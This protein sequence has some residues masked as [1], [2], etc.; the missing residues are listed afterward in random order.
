MS[1]PTGLTGFTGLTGPTGFTGYTGNT[2]PVGTATVV[3][4]YVGLTGT[5][6]AEISPNT[7]IAMTKDTGLSVSTHPYLFV[8]GVTDVQTPGY[9]TLVGV[10]PYTSGGTWNIG[11]NL[12]TTQTTQDGFVSGGTVK[13]YTLS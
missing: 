7:L 8:Q 1:G 9:V 12:L 10:Y 4:S 2:G 5:E 11:L 3:S 13:F 6:G